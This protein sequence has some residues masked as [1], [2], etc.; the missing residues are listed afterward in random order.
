MGFVKKNVSDGKTL[1]LNQPLK[2]EH[3]GIDES[4]GTRK[5]EFR[6]ILDS[7]HKGNIKLLSLSY[8]L[9]NII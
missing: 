4:F 9:E 1:T 8:N 3:L 5:V 2:Y 6:G 7:M